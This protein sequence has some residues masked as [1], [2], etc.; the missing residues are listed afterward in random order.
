MRFFVYAIVYASLAACVN[1]SLYSSADRT[2]YG[3]SEEK[4][5]DEQYRVRFVTRGDKP[6][7]AEEHAM[8][9]AAELCIIEGYFWFEVLETT[10]EVMHD[11]MMDPSRLMDDSDLANGSVDVPR[12]GISEGP[13]SP[14]GTDLGLGKSTSKTIAE[15]EFRMLMG[16][17]PEGAHIYSAKDMYKT[18]KH[19]LVTE[20]SV[21]Y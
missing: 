2:G 1:Y 11:N 17:R 14:Q 21:N 5:A 4:I 16:E 19:K 9:R 18:L 3:Y 12:S 8:L 20:K 6:D 10:T 13:V 7:I 15:L